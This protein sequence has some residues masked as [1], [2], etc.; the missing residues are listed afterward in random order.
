MIY[1]HR[2]VLPG[3]PYLLLW[4]DYLVY[5]DESKDELPLYVFDKRFVDKCAD[6]G[7]EYNVPE[8]F[9]VSFACFWYDI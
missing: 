8:V 2:I 1:R 4:Q 3:I 7:Q 9:P 5:A 6:L